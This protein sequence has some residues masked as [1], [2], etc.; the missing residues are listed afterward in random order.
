MNFMRLQISFS[1]FLIGFLAIVAQLILIREL[2]VVFYGNEL[3]TAI[4][5]CSW[6]VWTSLGSTILG[7]I[8]DNLPN[9]Q[10]VFA[11]AQ[12]LLSILLP[13]SIFTVRLSKIIWN[14]PVGEIV[15]LGRM[16][17]ISF[18]I[19]AP[20][21]LLSGFLFALGCSLHNEITGARK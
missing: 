14:I 3:S 6:L 1:L 18:S 21:C 12:L 8:T 5:L 15:D 2:L 4:I 13:A 17:L 7:R 9:K 11:L 19:L 20:F 16:M 10:K